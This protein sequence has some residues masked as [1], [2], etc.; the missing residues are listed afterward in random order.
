[1]AALRNI[2]LG[3]T[4]WE[5][6]WWWQLKRERRSLYAAARSEARAAGGSLL[7]VGA[8]DGDYPCGEAEHGDVLLDLRDSDEC[9]NT[10]VAGNVE[11][12]PFE[13][14][15]FSVVYVSHVME[16]VCDPRAAILEVH[17]V[18]RDSVYIAYPPWWALWVWL[19]PGHTWMLF[20]DDN[21]LGVR[22]KRIREGGCNA[23]TRLGV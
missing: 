7:V 10:F 20:E 13:D 4:A 21:D 12:L 15:S 1:M 3:L 8:P 22:F 16:H 5:F 23:P 2:L 14:G 9:P 18:A 19:V 11:N 17:R 6:Y